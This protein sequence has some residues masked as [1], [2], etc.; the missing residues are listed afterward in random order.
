MTFGGKLTLKF[1]F[2][3][4][5]LRFDFMSCLLFS[6]LPEAESTVEISRIKVGKREKLETLIRE[7]AFLAMYL[8]DEQKGWNLRLAN[9]Q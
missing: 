6:D 9:L 5:N 2:G 3:P 8:K 1:T 4:A 7:E